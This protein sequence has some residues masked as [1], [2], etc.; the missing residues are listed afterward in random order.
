MKIEST[1]KSV[2]KIFAHR[3]LRLTPIYMIVLAIYINVGL[4]LIDL[5]STLFISLQQMQPYFGSGP[6]WYLSQQP[7]PNCDTWCE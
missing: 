5:I 4:R 7:V 2:L 1:Q 3:F 6:F